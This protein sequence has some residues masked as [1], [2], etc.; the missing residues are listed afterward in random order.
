MNDDKI[1]AIYIRVSTEAQFEEGYSVDEQSER[2]RDYCKVYQ[3]QNIEEFIDGGETGSNLNRPQMQRLI[4]LCGENKVA[5]VVVYKLD[6]LSRSQKDTLYLIEDVF[7][8]NEPNSDRRVDF[9]SINEQL[10]TSTPYGRAMIGILSAFAQL[11]RENIRMRTGMGMQARIKSGLWA[12]GG[13]VPY[14][15][16][17]DRESGLLVPNENAPKVRQMFD[18]YLQGYSCNK[19]AEIFGIKYDKLVEQ[20]LT[21]I[22]YTGALPYKGELYQGQHE[23]IISREIFERTQK[24]MEQRSRSRSYTD[25]ENLLTGMLV[26]GKCGASMRYQQ[27]GKAG[28]KIYCYSQQRSKKNLIKDPACDNAKN[29]ANDI[30]NAVVRQFF[31]TFMFKAPEQI[32][33]DDNAVGIIDALSERKKELQREIKNLYGLFSKRPSSSLEET[34]GEREEALTALQKQIELA[35]KREKAQGEQAK[36]RE[37]VSE[38]ADAW[39]YMTVAEKRSLLKECI[40]KVVVTDNKVDVYF[41]L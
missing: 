11:E 14:G 4:S 17:Y 15:Y 12:G 33:G 22:I 38:L 37:R 16:D 34:I 40:E 32:D 5:R 21:H 1:T 8:A 23:P 35:Q 9:I 2:L 31:D 20:I 36:M 19:I 25:S 29:W 26:C 41:K 10:D 6:R 28:K 18:L 13:K 24:M 27:W 7:H 39:E 3:Y 30:D